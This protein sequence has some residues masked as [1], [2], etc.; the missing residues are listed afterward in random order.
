MD[1]EGVRFGCRG[2]VGASLHGQERLHQ[3]LHVRLADRQS[4]VGG[5][6]VEIVDVPIGNAIRPG[7]ELHHHH[8]VVF[9]LLEGNDQIGVFKVQFRK[10]NGE[11]HPV[12]RLPRRWASERRT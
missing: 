11:T 8:G 10:L 3:G 9:D 6:A 2:R 5:G 7:W 4:L 1:S 12:C